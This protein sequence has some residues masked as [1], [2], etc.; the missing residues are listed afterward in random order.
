M[1]F[2]SPSSLNLLLSFLSTKSGGASGGSQTGTGGHNET[3]CY[4][5]LDTQY[6][7]HSIVHDKQ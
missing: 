7:Q 5:Q 2:H 6:T 4:S 1:C 3:L